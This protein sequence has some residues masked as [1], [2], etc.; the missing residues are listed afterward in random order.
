MADCVQFAGASAEEWL[1]W[2]QRMDRKMDEALEKLN[3]PAFMRIERGE[4]LVGRVAGLE[5]RVAKIERKLDISAT[6]EPH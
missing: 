2:L 4:D 5:A 1:T 6:L 3:R